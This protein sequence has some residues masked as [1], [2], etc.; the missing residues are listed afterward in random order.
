MTTLSS[1]R[2][3]AGELQFSQNIGPILRAKI[4][5]PNNYL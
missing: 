5:E 2:Q 1:G 3:I 4:T